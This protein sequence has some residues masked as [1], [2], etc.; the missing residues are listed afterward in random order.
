MRFGRQKTFDAFF[1]V[2][3]QKLDVHNEVLGIF[4]PL[5]SYV[6]EILEHCSLQFCLGEIGEPTWNIWG[7][8]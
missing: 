2:S 4:I 3:S 5:S 6:Q 1:D 8:W 7:I